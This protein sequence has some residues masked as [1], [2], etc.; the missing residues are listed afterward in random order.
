MENKMIAFLVIA[1]AVGLAAGAGI[2]Y[3]VFDEEPVEQQ[4]YWFYL[5]YGDE[6]SAD[7]VNRWVSVEATSAGEAMKKVPGAVC[8]DSEE[9]GV[10]LVSIDG[11]GTVG[12]YPDNVYWEMFIYN[13]N[14]SDSSAFAKCWS[15]SNFGIGNAYSTCW[16]LAYHSYGDTVTDEGWLNSGPLATA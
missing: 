8:E 6:A 12:T 4:K 14:Y 10:S 13:G 3:L 11:L 7:K 5:D 16:Y 1:V 9:Y 15:S 2:G